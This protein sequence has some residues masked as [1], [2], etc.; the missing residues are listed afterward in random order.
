VNKYEDLK[1][2]GQ[3]NGTRGA[4]L[5]QVDSSRHIATVAI[6]SVICGICL[7]GALLSAGIAWNASTDALMT[8]N[9]LISLQAQHDEL[10]ARTTRLEGDIHALRS[11]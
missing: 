3:Q 7:S 6:C 9:R 4:Q 1:C 2:I 10:V 5:I 11:K 8:R